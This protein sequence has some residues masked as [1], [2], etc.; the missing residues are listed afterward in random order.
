MEIIGR[1]SRGSK[2][3][4]VYIPKNRIGLSIGNYVSIRPLEEQ[5]HV[6]KLYFYGVKEIEHLK[7]KIVYDIINSIDKLFGSYENLFIIGSFLD[8]GFNF[9]DIDLLI[10]T[11][12]NINLNPIKQSIEKKTGVRVH[13]LTL[14][15]EELNKG[16]ETDPLYQMMLSKCIAKKRFI[17]KTKQT[18]NYKL[19]DLHLLKSKSLMNNFDILSGSEK[20]NLVRNMTAIYLYLKDK[21][22]SNKLVDEEIKRGFEIDVQKIKQN[23]IDKK[24]FLNKYKLIYDKTFTKIL[25]GI[26]HG[27]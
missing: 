1:V 26:E 13:I 14:N 3:D 2:M 16:L 12:D 10:V 9:N 17:Y 22:T 11:K 20:Y 6:E 4:Q 19:L 25:R 8:K 15:T 7:L 27:A 18:I 23:I 21:K 5:K 24:D